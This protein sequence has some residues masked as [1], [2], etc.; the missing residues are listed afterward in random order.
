MAKGGDEGVDRKDVKQLLIIGFMKFCPEFEKLITSPEWKGKY[1]GEGNPDAKILIVGQECA[2]DRFDHEKRWIFDLYNKNWELWQSNLNNQSLSYDSIEPWAFQ[3]DL[4]P[5]RYNPFW[6]YK[7]QLYY[8]G[9][10]GT[11]RTCYNY[12]KFINAAANNVNGIIKAQRLM[13]LTYMKYCFATELNDYCIP[14]HSLD[15]E[16][17]LKVEQQE[18]ES[19]NKV[20]EHHI[21]ARYDLI[22]NHDCNFFKKFKVVLLATGKRYIEKLDN[23]AMFGDAHVI[24]I[25]QASRLSEEEFIKIGH[26]IQNYL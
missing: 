21:G 16:Y 11:S 24:Q 8:C 2:I 23:E 3:K 17:L 7:C 9:K 15:R 26:K 6:P 22:V 1:I 4:R 20:I 18:G 25:S 10:N 5:E 19:L 12:Q 13:P 14:K